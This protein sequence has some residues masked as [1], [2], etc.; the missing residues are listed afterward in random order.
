[1][2][3]KRLATQLQV[4][5]MPLASIVPNLLSYLR[6]L[7]WQVLTSVRTESMPTLPQRY[8]ES[9]VMTWLWSAGPQTTRQS[10]I[11]LVRP[12]APSG[13][14]NVMASPCVLLSIDRAGTR[15]RLFNARLD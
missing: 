11:S 15:W 9:P 10:F 4:Q 5:L 7:G 1:M 6:F 3:R 13:V 2:F 14:Q 12:K 8:P